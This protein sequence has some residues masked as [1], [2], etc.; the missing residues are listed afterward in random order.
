M[1]RDVFPTKIAGNYLNKEVIFVK[2]DMDKGAH[3]GD[4]EFKNKY[5]ITGYPT[6]I[7]FDH[8]GKQ[9]N[10]FCGAP[11]DPKEFVERMKRAVLGKK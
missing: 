6:F 10:Y 9:I 11:T 8:T 4:V 5:K 3:S 1:E 2:Y 7:V